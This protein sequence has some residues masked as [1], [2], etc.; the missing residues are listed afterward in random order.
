MLIDYVLWQGS[1][2]LVWNWT[3]A[4]WLNQLQ[5]DQSN[6]LTMLL[7]E[8]FVLNWEQADFWEAGKTQ[9]FFLTEGVVS[10]TPML[11]SSPPAIPTVD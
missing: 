9:H 6:V 8:S 5:L 4:L 10:D 2:F 11:S 7:L 1:R 3:E